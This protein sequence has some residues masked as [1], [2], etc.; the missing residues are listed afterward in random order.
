MQS[1][2]GDPLFVDPIEPESRMHCPNV[3]HGASTYIRR[4]TLT[5]DVHLM[6]TLLWWF[7]IG[8]Y[9]PPHQTPLHLTPIDS[10]DL[11]ILAVLAS[12]INTALFPPVTACFGAALDVKVNEQS[13]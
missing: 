1:W 12:I 3:D 4:T 13:S 5:Q 7:R 6:Y 8:Q 11:G 2:G 10:Q 9:N